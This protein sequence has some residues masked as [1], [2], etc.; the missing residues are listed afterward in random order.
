MRGPFS[1]T[2]DRELHP[3]T[4]T[5]IDGPVR[6]R[7]V[8]ES[9]V[10]ALSLLT[11]ADR[12]KF[13]LAAVVSMSLGVLDLIGVALIGLV[14]AVAV[15]GID[16]SSMPAS[17]ESLITRLGLEG[18]T[19]SQ[20]VGLISAVAVVLL[21]CKTMAQAVLTR[22]MFSFL[23]NRQADVAARLARTI[24]SRQL[25]DVQRWSTSEVLYALTSG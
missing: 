10:A 3:V 15:S 21:L 17:L 22:R 8:L 25:L 14:G 12:I 16:P 5:P 23:A 6:D 2:R 24:L 4:G 11:Q 1:K 13:V 9:V 18:F 20:L 19:S 7:T